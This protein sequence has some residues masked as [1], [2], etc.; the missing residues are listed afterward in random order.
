MLLILSFP[1]IQIP[2]VDHQDGKNVVN[3]DPLDH[4]ANAAASPISSIFS[5]GLPVK[6]GDDFT[7][8]QAL[9]S[10]DVLLIF[11]ASTCG[12]GAVLTVTNNFGQIG[13]SL[14]YS[15]AGTNTFIALLSI[16]DFIRGV[17]CSFISDTCLA[18]YGVSSGLDHDSGDLRAQL[19]APKRNLRRQGA[20]NVCFVVR[21]AGVLYDRESKLGS[22]DD[23]LL[24]HRSHCYRATFFVMAGVCLF[25]AVVILSM[26]TAKLYS[27]TVRK[28]LTG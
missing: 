1:A 26:R 13:S 3:V 21:V 18:S 7:I 24:C 14:G 19:P 28:R 27:V 22:R 25:A 23:E 12:I 15:Q 16:W 4:G 5:K 9:C 10:I 8:L 2:Q 20:G 6:R 11:A 17:G